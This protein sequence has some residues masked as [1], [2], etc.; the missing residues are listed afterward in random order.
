MT[1]NA[2]GLTTS[3]A[4]FAVAPHGFPALARQRARDAIASLRASRQGVSLG[5]LHS[6][7][8]IREGRR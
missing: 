4:G 3:M 1:D 8:L 6:T 5:R 7:D 2:A